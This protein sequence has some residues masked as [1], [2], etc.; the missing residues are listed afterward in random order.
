L[1]ACGVPVVCTDIDPY[2]GDLPVTRVRN[3][4]QDWIKAIRE[5]LADPDALASQGD[6]LRAAVRRDWMLEG[7]FLDQWA[8]A[9]GVAPIG[10]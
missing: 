6:A 8:R 3:R 5:H 10:L 7:E 4:H 2:Q 9:W 1:G